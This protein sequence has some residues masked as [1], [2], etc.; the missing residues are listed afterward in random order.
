MLE[1]IKGRVALLGATMTML[2]VGGIAFA[3]GA[4]A[5]PADPVEGAFADLTTKVTLYGGLVLGL[6][7]LTIGIFLG[8]K[9]LRKG[10]STS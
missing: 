10:V 3:G 4:S 9:W 1:N 7:L 5:T 6:V 2:M 8:I